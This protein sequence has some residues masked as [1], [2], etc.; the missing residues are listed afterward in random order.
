MGSVDFTAAA[1]VVDEV[2]DYELF[3]VTWRAAAPGHLR[4]ARRRARG[5]G[6]RRPTSVCQNYF[7]TN[8]G[9]LN[10]IQYHDQR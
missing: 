3:D 2:D 10:P 7:T 8:P 6:R 1:P 4:R 9:Y 5:L